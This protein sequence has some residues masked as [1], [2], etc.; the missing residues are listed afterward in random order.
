MVVSLAHS[1]VI[2]K[3]HTVTGQDGTEVGTGPMARQG[4]AGPETPSRAPTAPEVRAGGPE[5]QL[6]GRGVGG[7]G[8][9]RGG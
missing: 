7:A 5:T 8:K 9:P 2:G 1:P 3:T 4:P 6:L